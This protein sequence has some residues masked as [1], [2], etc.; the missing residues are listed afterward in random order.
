M[1][2]TE[3]QKLALAQRIHDEF[4]GFVKEEYYYQVED[5]KD[6]DE[7]TWEYQ[8]S[9]QDAEDIKQLVIDM[10]AVPVS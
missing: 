10:I 6:Q 9:Q 5:M 8:P 7:L 4:S 2:L 3:N 1:E